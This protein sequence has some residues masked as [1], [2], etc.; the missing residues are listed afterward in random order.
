MKKVSL[1]I[2]TFVLFLGML[3][4]TLSNKNVVNAASN[5]TSLEGKYVSTINDILKNSVKV[6]D[7]DQ[8]LLKEN[9]IKLVNNG[10]VK[11]HNQDLQDAKLD[12]DTVFI[13]GVKY[14]N[15]EIQYSVKVDY[16][17]NSIEKGSFINVVFKENKEEVYGTT[18]LIA[19][20]V[21]EN[22]G[23]GK[24]WVNGDLKFNETVNKKDVKFDTSKVKPLS[25]GCVNDCLASQGIASWVLYTA[26]IACAAT[27]TV[28]GPLTAGTAC[29][30]CLNGLGMIGV[31]VMFKCMDRC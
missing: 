22:T 18:E 7:T 5:D 13:Q 30:A 28:V 23:L 1:I 12:F 27:C 24:F 29:W 25:W 6:S 19:T 2:S 21:D 26:G 20:N 3:F 11:V 15:G 9:V 4:P 16:V 8:K 10:S 17:G 14:Q 31:Q